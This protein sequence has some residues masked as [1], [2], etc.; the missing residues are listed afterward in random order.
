MSPILLLSIA[1]QIAC[2]VHAVRTGRPMYWVFI[3]LIGSYIAVAIYVFAEVLPNMGNNPGARRAV[4]GLRDKVDPER[5]KRLAGRRLDL[6][7]TLENRSALAEQSLQSGDY[8]RAAELYR[9]SLKGLHKTD[10]QLMLGLAKAQFALG[11][12]HETKETLDALIAANPNFRSAEG[13]L[14]Y[15]R[16]IEGTG[17]LQA[18]LHEF[19][20][21]APGYPGE[22]GRARY[23]MLLKRDGQLEKAREVFSEIAK[24]VN[25]G[26]KYYRREQREWVEL[27][28]RESSGL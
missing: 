3:L 20:T 15:A 21:L 27:A 16:A 25:A 11:L 14:L 9:S 18:A 26:P 8:Q 13:H 23:G 22:E 17:N 28:E 10:P 5:G 7:D 19:E 1:L 6:A 12:F 4:R 2:A 24:R